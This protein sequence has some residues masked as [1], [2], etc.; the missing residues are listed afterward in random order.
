MRYRIKTDD[1]R[2]FDEIREVVAAEA[3]RLESRKRRTLAV[4]DISEAVIA[5]IKSLGGR[6]SEESAYDLD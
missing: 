3:I 6:V 4:E 1:D 2:Q 5:R